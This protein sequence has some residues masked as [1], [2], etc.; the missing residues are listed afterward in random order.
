MC[1]ITTFNKI[2]STLEGGPDNLGATFYEPS[3]IPEGFFMLTSYSQSNNKPLFGWVL[4]AK[5]VTSDESD[6]SSKI[7]E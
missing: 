6:E 1:Q 3:S 2:W 7:L 5:D 4:V